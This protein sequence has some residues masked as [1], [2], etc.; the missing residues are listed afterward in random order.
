MVSTRPWLTWMW[1]R[2]I[3]IALQIS[4]AW[5]DDKMEE[6]FIWFTFHARLWY[7]IDLWDWLGRSLRSHC[8]SWV[9][10]EVCFVKKGLLFTRVIIP[11]AEWRQCLHKSSQ[12]FVFNIIRLSFYLNQFDCSPILVDFENRFCLSFFANWIVIVVFILSTLKKSNELYDSIDNLPL[13]VVCVGE[14]TFLK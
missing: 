6:D 2:E 8:S 11:G 3:Q 9:G 5:N 14:Y 12:L 7:A 4:D 10:L 13:L 1:G